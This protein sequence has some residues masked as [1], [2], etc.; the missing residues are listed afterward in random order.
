MSKEVQINEYVRYDHGTE[1]NGGTEAA[2]QV[3]FVK[4]AQGSENHNRGE[5]K[6]I[7]FKTDSDPV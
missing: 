4:V 7:G 5:H 6:I 3:F 2:F 1:G